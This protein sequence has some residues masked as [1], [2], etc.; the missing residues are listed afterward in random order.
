MS[1]RVENL[2]PF[3]AASQVAAGVTAIQTVG[4]GATLR[5]AGGA[6]RG[7]FGG[8]VGGV[9]RG[10]A[11]VSLGEDALRGDPCNTTAQVTGLDGT[12]G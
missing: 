1:V 4:D 12:C 7:E 2:S 3:P 10:V 5:E 8:G 6:R 9:L 11:A